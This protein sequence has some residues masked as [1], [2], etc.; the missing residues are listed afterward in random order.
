MLEIDPPIVSVADTTPTAGVGPG[1]YTARVYRIIPIPSGFKIRFRIVNTDKYS[2]VYLQQIYAIRN[3]DEGKRTAA[4]TAL[5]HLAKACRVNTLRTP[6][7]LLDITVKVDVTGFK[8]KTLRFYPYADNVYDTLNSVL[9][10]LE[11]AVT[12]GSNDYYENELIRGMIRR[13]KEV[14]DV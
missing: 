13:I 14:V 8:C 12:W 5:S 10:D 1:L 11:V 3:K 2:D 6:K 7:Q 9:S 4:R